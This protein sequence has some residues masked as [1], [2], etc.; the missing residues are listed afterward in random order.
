[1]MRDVSEMGNW[2][3]RGGSDLVEA[4]FG[5]WLLPKGGSRDFIMARVAGG[6]HNGIKADE[7]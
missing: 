4:G 7:K 2:A 5:L 1:M 3:G 6:K